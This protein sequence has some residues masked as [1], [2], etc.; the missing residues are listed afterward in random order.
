MFSNRRRSAD[1]ARLAAPV[2]ASDGTALVDRL[3][4]GGGSVDSSTFDS[5]VVQGRYI[6]TG[7]TEKAEPD[8]R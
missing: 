1:K 8:A 6:K 3:G 2:V 7:E 5:T 4:V